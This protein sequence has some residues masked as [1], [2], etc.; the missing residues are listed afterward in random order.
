LLAVTV[1]C[2]YLAWQ[3]AI[4]RERDIAVTANKAR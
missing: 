4:V 2:V 3:V 1:F